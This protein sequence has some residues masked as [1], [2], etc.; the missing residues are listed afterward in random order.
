MII[1][2]NFSD[3]DVRRDF[4]E[5]R[6]VV[7]EKAAYAIWSLNNGN[8]IDKAPNGAESK[9]FKDLCN[10]SRWG[11]Q[12]WGYALNDTSDAEARRRAIALKAKVYGEHFREWFGDWTG[13]SGEL[14]PYGEVSKAVDDNGEPLLVFHGSPKENLEYLRNYE[15]ADP[16]PE[17]I[18]DKHTE[19]SYEW[20]AAYNGPME[21]GFPY[22]WGVME[23]DGK[24]YYHGMHVK[25]YGKP[26]E[27]TKEQFDAY[28]NGQELML[29]KKQYRLRDSWIYTSDDAFVSGTYLGLTDNG[30]EEYPDTYGEIYP[31]FISIKN[32]RVVEVHNNRWNA[33]PIDNLLVEPY[34]FEDEEGNLY[35]HPGVIETQLKTTR[36]IEVEERKAKK[37]DGIIF[38]HIVDIG[39]AGWLMGMTDEVS[40]VF[41]AA[42]S[43]QVKHVENNGNFSESEDKFRL[44]INA[45]Q[46]YEEL[47]NRAFW[48]MSTFNRTL[49]EFNDTFG[50]NFRYKAITHDDGT[51]EIIKTEITSPK[52]T[53]YGVDVNQS[54]DKKVGKLILDRAVV[55]D[56]LKNKFGIKIKIISDEEYKNTISR[57]IGSNCAIIGDTMYIRESKASRLTNEQFFEE[58]L[59]PMVHELYKTNKEL[60][61]KLIKQAKKDFPD[62]YKFIHKAYKDQ[63]Q[64]VINEEIIAQVL[65]KYLNDEVAITG[66]NKRNIREYIK[67]FFQAI[68]DK[69]KDLFGNVDVK[70]A[71]NGKIQASGRDIK[72]V[73]NFSQLAALINSRQLT[74]T[75]RLPFGEVRNNISQDSSITEDLY[76]AYEQVQERRDQFLDTV[77]Q[78]F[79]SQNPKLQGEALNKALVR[80][81]EQ[82][83]INY[84]TQALQQH[85]RELQV[86]LARKFNLAMSPEGY[87]Q[88]KVQDGKSL[89]YEHFINS[90]QEDTFKQYIL[91]VRKKPKYEQVGA[92]ANSTSVMNVL[93]QSLLEG[94]IAT[95]DKEMV[96]DYVRMFWTS[97]AIQ[98]ALSTLD[99]TGN[100]T[101]RK[102]EDKLVD[103]LT[104]DTY[105][106]RINAVESKKNS[107]HDFIVKLWDS[108]KDIVNK[109][110]GAKNFTA[111]EKA[112]LMTHVQ[113]AFV[114]SEDLSESKAYQDFY[115]RED[116]KYADATLLSE[117][118]K[119]IFEDIKKGIKVRIKSHTSRK[120]KNEKFIHEL[121]QRLSVFEKYDEE[122]IDD[123]F[124]GIQQF[125]QKAEEELGKTIRYIDNTLLTNPDYSK[126]DADTI[127]NIKYDLIGYYQK[128]LGQVQTLFDDPTSAIAVFDQMRVKNDPNALSL[129]NVSN[130]LVKKIDELSRVYH[131]RVVI[132]YVKW[133]LKNYV[134]NDD[135]IIDKQKFL[136]RLYKWVDQDTKYGDLASGEVLVGMASRS[137]SNLV[138][139]V[140]KIIND[141]D[142]EKNRIVLKKG[143]ELMRLYEQVRPIGAQISPVNWQ[144][145]FME[146]DKKCRSTGY[147]IRELNYGQFYQ[148]KDAYEDQLRAEFDLSTDDD[149][150]TIF[151]DEDYIDPNSVY[152]RYYDKLDKW[153]D[154]HCERRYTLDY[155]RERR[156]HLSPNTVRL[157]DEKQREINLL[158]QKGMKNGFFYESELSPEE[159]KQLRALVEQKKS[160]GRHYNFSYDKN[161]I[162]N[163]EEKEGDALRIAEEITSWNSFIQDKV[164]YKPNWMKY[165]DAKQA[166][167]DSGATQQEIDAFE[168]NNTSLRITSEFWDLLKKINKTKQPNSRLQELKRRHS[169][170]INYLKNKDG[171]YSPILNKLGEGTTEA[172]KRVWK[173]LAA[174]EQEMSDIRKNL[175]VVA[176]EEIEGVSFEDIANML[177]IVNAD[178]PSISY[179]KHIQ[180]LWLPQAMSNQQ[181]ADEFHQMFT[182]IDA[183][184]KVRYL[185]AF[186]ILSP[187]QYKLNVQG[188][189]DI[190]TVESVPVGQ[191][192][193]LDETSEYVNDKFDVDGQSM[194]PKRDIYYN[195]EWD[196]FKDENSPLR[197]F[198]DK[199]LETMWA[200]ND[201]IPQKASSRS[202]LLPQITGRTMAMFGSNLAT[203]ELF[204]AM[205]YALK[206][207]FTAQYAEQQG[208]VTT[209]MDVSRR[210]DGSIVNNIPIRFVQRLQNPA[211]QS[212]DV[213]GSVML[214]YDMAVNFDLKS[215]K[216]ASLELIE[217]AID[218]SQSAGDRKLPGQYSKVKNIMSQKVYGN[219]TTL[220][221]NDDNNDSE[222]R[223]TIQIAKKFKKLTSLAMLGGNFTSITVGY[224]DAL[225]SLTAD[226]VG[227]KYITEQ[228]LIYAIVTVIPDFIKGL[229]NLGEPIPND[230]LLACMQF[231]QLSRSNS[232]IFGR[233]DQT[234]ISRFIHQYA[235]MGGYTISDY[236]VSAIMVKATYHHMKLVTLPD[237]KKQFLSRSQ[238]INLF[239][240]YGYSRKEAINA[241]NSAKTTLWNA[242]KLSDGQFTLR[243]EF[244]PYVTKKLENMIQGRLEDRTKVYNGVIPT[245][246][247]AKLQQ[248]IF[249]SYISL[250][251]NFMINAYWERFDTEIDYMDDTD[252]K[253]NWKS[254][255]KRDDLVGQNLETGETK[256]ALFKDF[257]RGMYKI[258]M[259]LKDLLT[260]HDIRS[261]TEDQRYAVR[262]CLA[263]LGLISAIMFGWMIP[264]V[265]GAREKDYKDDPFWTINF[266]DPKKKGE[267]QNRPLIQINT[268][269]WQKKMLNWA[270][271]ENALLS[272]KLFNESITPWSPITP[273]EIVNN[274]TVAKSYLEDMGRMWSIGMDLMHPAK[275]REEVTSGGYQHMSRATRDIC[276]IFAATGIDNIIR[277]FHT[278]GVKSKFNFYRGLAPISSILPTQEEWNK[279]QGL[280]KHGGKSTG[281]GKK[282]GQKSNFSAPVW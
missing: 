279:Q 39:G 116:G 41:V 2:P 82:S 238:T 249:G 8:A 175:A 32:P 193:D 100:M 243:D 42:N 69:F 256:G 248:N 275:L 98:A 101:S 163:I 12:R 130:D 226:A 156:R 45:E 20:V 87:Y 76:S 26:E 60:S 161:G 128:L 224:L 168:N 194:Q 67:D 30:L 54:A 21:D 119:K 139:V 268:K 4:D 269:N 95:F 120:L 162:L 79:K 81:R 70:L 276:K 37:H 271:W 52:P 140:N 244:K 169:E 86:E 219:E 203:G 65:A 196:K 90:L 178:D 94:D 261:L 223:D 145:I 266:V 33:I 138:K 61:E 230:K 144:K 47:K 96:R 190:Q 264:A 115:N 97:D 218:P 228:D 237:G 212:T 123:V 5:L 189:G 132:P 31:L 24:Y 111:A 23:R 117:Q 191:F 108:L 151:P 232:E 134:D 222:H 150:N 201:M 36:D 208:D 48:W 143:H 255:Y 221:F 160:L 50:T 157:L 109:V 43:N 102:L 257:C 137:K 16:I 280:G 126:W 252:E 165:D 122:N 234:R 9:L 173:E 141:I 63:G 34:S 254:A 227:R 14:T 88:V 200:A 73:L 233:S 112:Q 68:F 103:T 199:L 99:T 106:E 262:R 209:N 247:K 210:P 89:M 195:K 155:Y 28:N 192:S 202:Y 113:E 35:T 197:Q 53:L 83:R 158:K 253:L 245:A 171:F 22:F 25:K 91:H 3:P 44:N 11:I 154:Q 159:L 250:M 176:D 251:R 124:N 19:E 217:E 216:L 84:N 278:A 58:F 231:N 75:D 152:N 267:I 78:T 188:Y 118:D 6:S 198:Y 182:Y 149:G 64:D 66:P 46:R 121:E 274:P 186:T 93:Y 77:V 183:K 110:L 135:T 27:I 40:N 127:N 167:I 207:T 246:E 239:K 273:M 131:N 136:S 205:G 56:Y 10:Y 29:Y 114:L 263:E 241:Y 38:K 129:F 85:T 18:T 235:L 215:Q 225:R 55:L 147:W 240:K 242:Y 15:I 166:L 270:R 148:D 133:V 170:I 282:N 71:E 72:D 236:L 1:C 220:T 206:D 80:V 142:R 7:G 49:A 179:L 187:T 214:Y 57:T 265:T 259:M 172:S 107:I 258:T 92:V 153:L 180:D 181:A 277:D 146:R 185:S 74:F 211:L 177:P 104:T 17:V 229:G 213:L 184:G 164:K 281:T 105:S 272:T 125:L 13:K 174:I 62:L 260:H 59:H 51:K 204:S